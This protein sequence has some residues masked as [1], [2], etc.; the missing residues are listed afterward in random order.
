LSRAQCQL[1]AGSG[2]RR[3]DVQPEVRQTLDRAEQFSPRRSS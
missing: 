3:R 1:K 2:S